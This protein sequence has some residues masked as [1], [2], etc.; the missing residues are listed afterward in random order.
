M[1]I[2]TLKKQIN[3]RIGTEL[4][5]Q[6]NEHELAALSQLSTLVELP[7]GRRFVAEGSIGQEA[8]VVV[9]GQASV[10]RNG[11]QIA[12]VGKGSF[13]GEMSLVCNEPRNASLV[14]DTP[15]VLAVLSRREF[16]SL[17]SLCPRLEYL[18]DKEIRKR[19]AA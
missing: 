7:A 9:Q 3:P 4:G 18:V 11:E 13:L 10:Q 6:L 16:H 15:V 8:L 12:T 19:V 5:T 14:A 17:M 2:R 1:S